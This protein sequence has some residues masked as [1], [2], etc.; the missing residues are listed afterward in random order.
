MALAGRRGHGGRRSFAPVL[1]RSADGKKSKT[2][3]SLMMLRR[4]FPVAAVVGLLVS[5]SLAPGVRAQGAPKSEPM[6][7]GVSL[8]KGGEFDEP[9]PADIAAPAGWEAAAKPEGVVSQARDAKDGAEFLRLEATAPNQLVLVSQSV[10]IPAGAKGLVVQARFRTA[11]V[12]FGK[13]F[14]NDAR[15]RFGFLDAS[16]KA[17]GK[18]PP[19]I[20]FS[21]HAKDWTFIEKKFLVA[22]GATTLRVNLALNRPATG[23]LDMD[24]LRV[25]PMDDAEA[26]AL[27]QAPLLAAQAKASDEAEVPALLALPPIT[28][29]LKVSGN[30]LLNDQGKRVILRGVNVPSLEWS[31]KGEQVLRSAKVALLDW[32]ANVIRVPVHNAYWFGRAKSAKEKGGDPEA[33]RA[34]V[35]DLVKIAAGQGAYL[36][37]DLHLY[38]GPKAEAVEFWKDAAARYKDN[39]AVLFDLYNEPTGITWELWQKGG[40]REVKDKKTGET[41]V[42]Q[43]VGMQALI[44]AVR[45]TGARN[46]V[47]CGG[48]EYAYNLTGVLDGK[49]L[50]PGA[51]NGLIYA[52]HFYNW[53]RNW[54]KNFLGVAAK[55]PVLVGEFGADVKKMSFI[56]ASSQEDPYTWMPDALGMMQKYELNWT[57]FSLHPKA[58]PVLIKDWTYEPT[59]FFGAFV[60]DALA[61][62]KF[63]SKKLR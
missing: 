15:A 39:P 34:I 41:S 31:A 43:V 46:I 62:K 20:I 19:D 24:W 40:P 2:L 25:G 61:G 44:D 56:K 3:R 42:V 11:N 29:T 33:Y 21:S 13:G 48:L 45:S 16:G 59:P 60:K 36:I 28:R 30:K 10:A 54:E 50:N 17:A 14:L 38:G 63:E 18:S 5:I 9:L 51:G 47:I 1:G 58:T 52:T 8:A 37:L 26:D 27:I 55:Y 23:T 7:A 35:D 22:D 12:K 49:A 32:K 6:P 57:A 4:I 53:H